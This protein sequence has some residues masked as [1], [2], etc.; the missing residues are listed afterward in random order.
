MIHTFARSGLKLHLLFYGLLAAQPL[1]AGGVSL[2][3]CDANGVPEFRQT[4]CR[5]G[6]GLRVRVIEASGGMT[7]SEPALRLKQAPQ[8]PARVS[9]T[10]TETLS[11]IHI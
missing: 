3:R 5:E 11:L 7:P 4:W 6:G 10:P 8:K 9:R 2:Y 1:S